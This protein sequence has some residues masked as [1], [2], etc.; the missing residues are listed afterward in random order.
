MTRNELDRLAAF[1]RARLG[2]P[3]DGLTSSTA[4]GCLR[5][6]EQAVTGLEG[7]L[8]LA[9]HRPA[10]VGLDEEAQRARA[11]WRTLVDMAALWPDHPDQ[12]ALSPPSPD[13]GPPPAAAA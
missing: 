12:P 5:T 10:P 9:A 2:A 6:L 1:L 11:L 3:T 13:P 8:L 7:Y 4:A